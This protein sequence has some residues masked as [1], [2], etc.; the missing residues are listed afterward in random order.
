MDTNLTDR[1]AR[2]QAGLI[3]LGVGAIALAATPVLLALIGSLD[4]P[5]VYPAPAPVITPTPYYP[6]PAPH[7]VRPNVV[8]I[9]LY[10]RTQCPNCRVH[11]D[12]QTNADLF[13]PTGAIGSLAPARKSA[14]K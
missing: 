2:P 13:S 5:R 6:Q 3:V 11:L 8:P 7:V 9:P 12:V 1:D 10:V 4:K 14:Q